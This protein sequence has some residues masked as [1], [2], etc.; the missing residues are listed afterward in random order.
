VLVTTQHGLPEIHRAGFLY[1]LIA[2]LGAIPRR[3]RGDI[4]RSPDRL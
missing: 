4:R 2:H 3:V 1:L